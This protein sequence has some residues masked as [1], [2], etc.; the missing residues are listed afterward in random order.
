MEEPG[1]SSD[2]VDFDFERRGLP[3]EVGRVLIWGLGLMGGSLAL[4]LRGKCTG[5]IGV[6]VDCEVVRQAQERGIVDASYTVDE[7]YEDPEKVFAGVGCI[8]L[9]APVRAILSILE[10]L[11][12]LCLQEAVV[13]DLGS[14][15]EKIVS[16]MAG[17]PERFD[18]VGGH[19][20]CGK[21]KA[22]LAYAEAAIYHQ[23]PFAL[24]SL[25]RTTASAKKIAEGLATLAGANPVW[26]EADVHDR[27]VAASSHLPFLVSSALA[28]ATPEEVKALIGTGF[29]SAARLANSSPRMMADIL[30][31]NSE[32]IRTVIAKFKDQLSIYERLLEQQDFAHL[33]EAFDRAG[34]QYRR[35]IGQ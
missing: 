24:V 1:F 26:L 3:L 31:T 18:P 17:L 15:K 11:P 22:S 30:A 16:A 25:S 19:P 8:I 13:M 23:A 27:W 4:A 32:N 12:G 21:E 6:D 9:A 10:Q 28:F 2:N 20:M 29:R 35:L 34:E 7:L 33:E 14:T 5:L